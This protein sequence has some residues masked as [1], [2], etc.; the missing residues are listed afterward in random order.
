MMR[1]EMNFKAFAHK[2]GKQTTATGRK[3]LE[4]IVY[5]KG[6]VSFNMQF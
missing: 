1:C 3:I 5:K 6:K 2:I 4:E